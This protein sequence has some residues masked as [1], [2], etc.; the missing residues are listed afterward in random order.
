MRKVA[1][2]LAGNDASGQSVPLQRIIISVGVEAV[3]GQAFLLVSVEKLGSLDLN[4]FEYGV[5]VVIWSDCNKRARVLQLM[6]VG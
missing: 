6:H 2:A 4:I 3:R 1:R 5:R